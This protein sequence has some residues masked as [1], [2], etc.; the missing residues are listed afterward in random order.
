MGVT[1]TLSPTS[2]LA[3]LVATGIG[4]YFLLLKLFRVRPFRDAQ[5]LI[6]EQW[7]EV[8]PPQEAPGIQRREDDESEVSRR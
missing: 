4:S 2:R 7:R 5:L 6:K 8:L 3:I 1:G